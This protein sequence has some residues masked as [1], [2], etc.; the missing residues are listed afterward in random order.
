[1]WP[2]WTVYTAMTSTV[3]WAEAERR[4]EV[5]PVAQRL[6]AVALHYQRHFPRGTSSTQ[7]HTSPAFKSIA[8]S[9]I[10]QDCYMAIPP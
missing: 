9:L 3:P 7:G 5:F 2:L 8:A 6:H 4:N 1:M 10:S